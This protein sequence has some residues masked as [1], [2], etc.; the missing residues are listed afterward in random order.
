MP[1]QDSSSP[2]QPPNTGNGPHEQAGKKRPPVLPLIFLTVVVDLIGFGIVI[3]VLPLIADTTGALAWQIGLLMG[4]YSGMQF[5]LAPVFG[6]LSDRFGRRPILIF[7]MLGLGIGYVFL[8]FAPSIEWMLFARV[9]QGICGANLGAAQAAVADVTTPEDRA[10]GMG[11]I[12]AAFGIGFV[13]GPLIG[14]LASLLTAAAPFLVAALLSFANAFLVWRLLPETRPRSFAPAERLMWPWQRWASLR[15]QTAFRSLVVT[16]LVVTTGF[17]MMTGIFALYTAGRY[18]FDISANGFLFAW[19]GFLA[20]V[21]QGGMVGRLSKRF[22]E[23]SLAM[24]GLLLTAA[25]LWAMAWSTN[26]V[27][28]IVFSSFLALGNSLMTPSLSALG[29]R[30]STA[31]QQGA[32]LGLMQSSASLGRLLGPILGGVLFPLGALGLP[33]G[34]LALACAGVIVLS[35]FVFLKKSRLPLA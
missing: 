12:G 3:P 4:I 21:V 26:S 14:G 10:K 20:I 15:D 35:A 32:R 6:Q 19:I 11:L 34:G 30:L 18:G 9:W 2:I 16:S 5:L 29:S 28:F 17:S 25:S 23:W 22:G 13:L 24:V 27:M 8:A 31:E 33:S 7:S 1:R